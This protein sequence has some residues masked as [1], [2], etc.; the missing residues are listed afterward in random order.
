MCSIY[1]TLHTVKGDKIAAWKSRYKMTESKIE[2]RKAN[3]DDA[4]AILTVHYDA[5]HRVA[6]KD[7]KPEVLTE[8]SPEVDQK[9]LADFKKQLLE[10][11][12][13]E[14]VYVAELDGNIAG[15]GA[16][17]PG[18]NELRAVYV[19]P[20]FTRRSVGSSILNHL[21]SDAISLGVKELHLDSSLTAENFYLVH[22]YLI[23]SRGSHRLRSGRL[24]PCIHMY[25]ELS[26][27]QK[28]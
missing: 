23:K 9:R 10:N 5:V 19:S 17:V 6:S 11:K 13:G 26:P 14:R 20:L 21:E 7:Y 3:A 2:I 27:L 8:W 4:K 28:D 15:F 16:I 24:M 22:G 12:D 1:Y 18:N 25:K